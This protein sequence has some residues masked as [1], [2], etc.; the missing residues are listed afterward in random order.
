MRTPACLLL[1]VC[2][3]LLVPAQYADE[4]MWT[5]DNPPLKFWREKYGFEPTKDWLDHLRLATVRLSENNGAGA[6]GCFVSADGLIFTNQ[7]VGAGQVAKLSSQEHDYIK[8]GFYAPTHAAELRCPDMEANLLVAY[9]DV[10]QRIHQAIK[11]GANDQEAA[12]QRRAAIVEIEK[13]ANAQGNLKGEVVPLYNGGEYWLYRFKRYTDVRLVFVPEEQIAYFGGDHDNFTFPRYSLD[14]A[15]LRVYE[16]GAPAKIDHY[17]KW[18]PQEIKEGELVVVPGFPGATQRLSTVAQIRYQRDY[19]TPL[20]LQIIKARMAALDQY[21]ERGAEESRQVATTRRLLGNTLKRLAGQLA[22][23]QNPRVFR[24]KELEEAGFRKAVGGKAEWQ[25]A[26][27]NP[28]AQLESA[29]QQLPVNGKRLAYSNLTPS[30]LGTLASLFV[31]YAE[32]AV[33]PNGQRYEEFRD[34]RL[35]SL[36]LNLLSPAPIYLALEEAV[37]TA[38]LTDAQQALGAKDPFVKAALNGNTPAAAVQ[39]ALRG[40]QLPRLEF[41]RALL[42]QGPEAIAKSADPLLVLARNIE[43]II[44]QLR[45]WHEERVLQVEAMAGERLANARFAVYG[46]N[47]YP[48]ANFSLRITYGT[49]AGYEEE[50]KLVPFKTTFFGLFERATAFGEKAPFTLPPRWRMGRTQLDLSTPLNFVY[51]ADTIGG[52]SGSPVV[53]RQGEIVGINFDSN[54]QK[55][56]NRYFYVDENEGSRA[57]GIHTA[58]IVEA[59]QKLYGAGELVK[60][61]KGR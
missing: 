30:R 44:R 22:G 53:N 61:I 32:E 38:W 19:G 1:A 3:L 21:A 25:R 34:N 24:R 39:K 14:I 43:P 12:S 33:N 40:T 50:T 51:S 36:R 8:E 41:R 57:V 31:R 48:E 35:P 26:F 46:K 49:V 9:E 15:F 13:E 52:N 28:W 58:A 7:H 42:D 56:P 17:L 23:L 6:T 18:A 20:Q 55:L 60:E 45:A 10:T 27:G 54:L 5:F 47:A 11:P 59:L 2:F 16:N 37:V 4:G 29:Y